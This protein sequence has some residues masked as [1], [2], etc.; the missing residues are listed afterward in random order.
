VKG[1]YVGK[2]EGR[3]LLRLTL[4]WNGG[5]VMRADI[6]GDFFAHPEEGFDEAESALIGAPV[7]DLGRTFASELASRGVV[8]FGLTPDDVGEAAAAIVARI[9]AEER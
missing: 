3:K 8:L 7:A 2:A 9:E 1:S 4:E 6:R 5:V